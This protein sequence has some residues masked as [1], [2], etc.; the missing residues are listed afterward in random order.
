[1]KKIYIDL[2]VAFISLCLIYGCEENDI[3]TYSG[4]EFVQFTQSTAKF[5]VKEK[6]EKNYELMVGTTK[7]TTTD[8]N[9]TIEVDSKNSTAIEG[10][11][12]RLLTPSVTIPAGEMTAMV[13]IESMYKNLT[14][15]GVNLVLLIKGADEL[16][17]PH[18]GN[19]CTLTMSQF[20]ELNM[21]K[22]V[23]TFTQ[24]SI[25]P[26]GQTYENEVTIKKLTDNSIEIYN[27]SGFGTT[28]KANVNFE[29]TSITI[30]PGQT[31]VPDYV[32]S[33]GTNFGNL[34]MAKAVINGTQ[35]EGIY[36]EAPIEGECKYTGQIILESWVIWSSSK[37]TYF[38][39]FVKTIF[40]PKK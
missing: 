11:D 8:L 24:T 12:F 9:L 33:D 28:M 40:T 7:P 18:F 26:A 37:K 36:E 4:P 22:L 34:S 5:S 39:G 21:E 16:L 31:L 1:M 19:S 35:L 2:I 25:N 38:D 6:G 14:P 13:R 27:I 32:H 23:G 20:Y 29:E 30:L 3:A 17:N 15:E 10:R